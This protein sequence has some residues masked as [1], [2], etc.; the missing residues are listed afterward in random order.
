MFTH[1]F[2]SKVELQGHSHKVSEDELNEDNI[3]LALLLCKQPGS[4]FID[5]GVTHLYLG[6]VKVTECC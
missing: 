6:A 1:I 3:L 2:L 5:L 4:N